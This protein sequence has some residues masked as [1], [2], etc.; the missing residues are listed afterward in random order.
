MKNDE[1]I[2]LYLNLKTSCQNYKSGIFDYSSND[3]ININTFIP[4][5]FKD[6][7][8]FVRT[9]IDTIKVYINYTD[10][11]KGEEQLLFYIDPIKKENHFEI[12]RDLQYTFPYTIMDEENL[13]IL[14]N[15][16]WYVINSININSKDIKIISNNEDY[17]LSEG[18]ILKFGKVKYI[19]KE[20]FI[21]K[22]NK[23][24]KSENKNIKVF[25]LI[26]EPKIKKCEYCNENIYRLCKCKDEF[27]HENCMR[28]WIEDRLIVPTTNNKQTITNYYFS[29]YK[30]QEFLKINKDCEERDHFKCECEK[31][32]T[33]YPLKFKY[34]NRDKEKIID[35]YQIPINKDKDYM[36]L[37]SL[38]YYDE[39]KNFKKAIHVIDLTNEGEINIGRKDSNDIIL[40]DLSVCPEHA[41]IIYKDG[42]L[43]IKNKSPKSG[44]LVLIRDDSLILSEKEIY[45]QVD[46][47][48]IEA[49]I[50]KEKEFLN[51]YKNSES[52]YPIL[53]IN[54][55]NN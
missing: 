49:K 13:N 5:K 28:D 39:N 48:F 50:M 33:Y 1:M 27:V 25:N 51:T 20:I 21:K 11:I 29:I 38:E 22:K 24:N 42:K 52:K 17:Y 19:V 7:L 40:E 15:C 10:I 12:G 34:K 44:T 3:N 55:I 53:D 37:E 2:G 47:T 35:L 32:N 14:K 31:C 30:C 41:V 43:L 45:L 36:I 16:I 23:E 54:N 9:K 6:T 26:P 8:F 4:I 46:K 18:D